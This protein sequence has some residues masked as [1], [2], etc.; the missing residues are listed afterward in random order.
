MGKGK[1]HHR[2][3]VDDVGGVGG[4]GGVGGPGGIG[5]VGGDPS[6]DADGPYRTHLLF[7]SRKDE[8]MLM[9]SRYEGYVNN[10]VHISSSTFP[11]LCSRRGG[12]GGGSGFMKQVF[13]LG[14][15]SS[16]DARGL[17]QQQQQELQSK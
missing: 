16:V 6:M 14:K 8:D 4:A 10:I 1:F 5:G 13:G 3:G 9:E 7:P 17:S 2:R 12:S 11:P 15:K